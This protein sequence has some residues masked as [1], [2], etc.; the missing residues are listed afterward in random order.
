M[1]VHAL[2]TAY[3]T[4]ELELHPIIDSLSKQVDKIIIVNNSS[5]C[6]FFESE[7]IEVINLNDNF[8]IA[9]AQSIGMAYSFSS[10]ADFVLQMDQDSEPDSDLVEKLLLT[11]NELSSLGYNVGIVGPQD[12][13][14]D[15]LEIN[16]AR[17]KIGRNI[18]G[19]NCFIVEQTLSS[20][21]LISKSAYDKTGGMNDNL[22]IDAVDEE[23][24]WR[25]RENGFIVVKNNDVHLA[26]KI[27]LGNKTFLGVIKL[28]VS[29]P[30]RYYYQFRNV[31]L[32]SK[33]KSTPKYWKYSLWLK[34]VFK[35]VVFPIQLKS[36]KQVFNFMVKGIADGF[37]GKYGRIDKAYNE[38]D[39]NR[40][41]TYEQ[42]MD[43]LK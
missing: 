26:H 40:F 19:T 9:K 32:L 18:E 22:F 15:S 10:G 13:D 4:S 25:V 36:G 14:K 29:A 11:Y 8:G 5:A 1:I 28:G 42:Y 37:K 43:G 35:I 24:C 20:G 34:M 21:S 39:T 6:L 27:G 31:I 3:E 17:V 2:I 41:K 23:Y 33:Y 7:F 38:Y 16:K 12:I 30:I